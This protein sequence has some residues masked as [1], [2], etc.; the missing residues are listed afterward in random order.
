MSECI[1]KVKAKLSKENPFTEKQIEAM[2]MEVQ[3]QLDLGLPLTE[4][5]DQVAN[6]SDARIEKLKNKAMLGKMDNYLKRANLKREVIERAR[7]DKDFMVGDFKVADALEHSW[8]EVINNY[9]QR[10]SMFTAHFDAKLRA[11]LQEAELFEFFSNKQNESKIRQEL[12]AQQVI[13]LDDRPT[14]PVTGDT[15]AFNVARK[16][17][18][19]Y[20]ELLATESMVGGNT[21]FQEG[22]VTGQMW[23]GIKLAQNFTRDE[24]IE[25]MLDQKYEGGYLSKEEWGRRFDEKVNNTFQDEE[26]LFDNK[27]LFP[28]ARKI[29]LTEDWYAKYADRMLAGDSMSERIALDIGRQ[30]R[31]IAQLDY[32][33]T[34][35]REQYDEI[36]NSIIIEGPKMKDGTSSL[37]KDFYKN[38]LPKHTFGELDKVSTVWEARIR[39]WTNILKK[40][41]VVG[42]L[43]SGVITSQMDW[44]TTAIRLLQLK[45]GSGNV[46]G[47]LGDAF[48]DFAKVVGK[49]DPKM[50][51]AEMEGWG[52][53]M[54][55]LRDSL[56]EFNR[57]MDTP[58]S[59]S[60]AGKITKTIDEGL[61][62]F[63]KMNTIEW[64]TKNKVKASY[65]GVSRIAFKYSEL[66]Y[67]QLNEFFGQR[68]RDAGIDE[69]LWNFVRKYA[70]DKEN[71]YMHT[72]NMEELDLKTFAELDSSATSK[73][74]LTRIKMSAMAKWQTFLA[75]EAQTL[76]MVPG[77]M[78]KARLMR[79]AKTGTVLGSMTNLSMQFRSIAMAL[80]TRFYLPLLKGGLN[81]TM[82]QAIP[83]LMASSFAI[84]YA[85]DTLMNRKRD[86]L[87]PDSWTGIVGLA[88]GLPFMD[89]ATRVFT[90]GGRLEGIA[91]D[92][93]GGAVGGDV[94][95]TAGRFA[96][97]ALKKLSGEYVD[98]QD[99]LKAIGRTL[100]PAVP[101][102]S[103]PIIAPIYETMM[104]DVFMESIDPGYTAEKDMKNQERGFQRIVGQ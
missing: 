82:L 101:F 60:H 8:G 95:D 68:L 30:A 16:V 84:Q 39:D 62:K 26:D 65:N 40:G 23:D 52:V 75:K 72:V 49:T 27:K 14:S 45:N 35:A 2:L 21:G 59:N 81:G 48:N 1:Q 85:K 32:W 80:G 58:I 91:V 37:N 43:F 93:V 3:N 46:L 94:L 18:Q 15:N 55:S 63:A 102:R 20:D 38:I 33:G 64:F 10:V 73:L 56:S 77:T 13:K 28:R 53:A 96:Q 41:S 11:R 104:Y 36:L 90:S 19:T 17:Q 54:E 74:S 69:N 34:N 83:T 51:E 92:I 7:A 61:G 12:R 76:T 31:K 50:F 87:K 9:D 57:R 86:W 4:V 103:V 6:I 78:E 44:A 100:G 47:E 67:G 99:V 66:E 71:G 5:L 22:R 42:K 97:L 25:A 79:N 98:G 29:E 88:F 89:N 70:V 24:Y